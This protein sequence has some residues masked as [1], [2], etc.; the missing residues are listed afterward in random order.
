MPACGAGRVAL[1]GPGVS[2]RWLRWLLV[3]LA[4][5]VA[6]GVG[7]L[8]FLPQLLDAPAIQAYI[9]QTATHAV[10]RP[11]RFASVSVS[12]LPVPH[13]TLK[14]LEV[15]DDPR[16]GKTPLLRV[17]EVRIGVRARPLLSLRIE[18]ASITLQGAKLELVEEN[19]R[20]NVTSVTAPAAPPRPVTRT[21]P[22]IPGS[23]A[24]GSVMV[25]SI[26]VRG[27]SINVRR[28]GIKNGDLRI[29]GLD[30]TFSGVGGPELDIRGD[31]RVEPGALRI[32]S[33]RATAGV[34]GAAEMPLKASFDLDGA[35]IGPVARMLLGPAPALTGPVSGKLQLS[36]TP[37]RL[38]GTGALDLSHVTVSEE[39]TQCPPPAR[40]Q[41][42]LEDVRLPILL[43]PNVF[44][45]APL[46]GK[47]SKGTVAFNL[48][49]GLDISP[50]VTLAAIKIGGVQLQPVLQDFLCQGFAVSGPLDLTG[51]LSMRAAD[52][53]RTMNGT[54][55]L[56]IGAGR[57]VGE[58]ALRLVRGVLEAG[59]VFDMALRGKL[60]APGHTSL[61][62]DSITGSYRIV[63]GVVRTDDLL[64]QSKDLRV[65]AAG[66][67]ALADG[68]TDMKVVATQGRNQLRAQVTGSGGALRVVP[69]GVNVKEP[70]EVKKFLDRL[71]R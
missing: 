23:A 54:G 60:A 35:D 53:L 14:D 28:H 48:T 11:V 34:R 62:F 47:V 68:R 19:G 50:D 30:A 71:L 4:L 27:A 63:G 15:A 39:R 17:P 43:K 32:R 25:S 58:G 45:S 37:A 9:A 6:L 42:V 8:A 26:R 44:E 3:V 20:W 24:M 46:Q 57:V 2:R 56:K 41:L 7:T 21:V 70:A 18:L 22:G 31:G 13:V 10:G 38:S 66:T 36:G 59:N 1:R 55:Q 65:T 69:T 52:P 64:Y 49:A 67:Y 5:V 12:L 61:E 29:E 16:F 51:E 40:R 33:L